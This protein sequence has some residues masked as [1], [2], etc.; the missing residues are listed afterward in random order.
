MARIED[1][2]RPLV[3]R[4]GDGTEKVVAHC[5]PHP[6]GLLYLDLFWHRRTPADAA[7]LV[8]GELRGEG[9]WKIAGAVI[10]VLGCHNTDPQLQD[11]YLP[12]RDYLEQHG[13][14]YPAR[15]Q[16]REIARRLGAR[17]PD[18]T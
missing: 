8:R 7:H 6:L 4:F 12:W 14:L 3:I 5:F 1:V 18:D 16:V 11:Q 13:E 15:A 2:T 9:P 17:L 10:R